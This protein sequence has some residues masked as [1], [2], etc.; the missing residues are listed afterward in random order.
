MKTN[1]IPID[2]LIPWLGIALI[3]GGLMV[4]ATYLHLERKA[5]AFE[6]S[7]ATLDRLCQEVQLSAELKRLHEGE[8]DQAAQDIDLLLCGDIL[9]TNAELASAD[10]ETR[11]LVQNTFRRIARVRPKTEGTNAASTQEH[12]FDQMAA[13]RVLTLALAAPNIAEKQ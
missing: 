8:V 12:V 7:T 13:E 2:R 10:R 5:H 3:A 1:H 6:A 4:A 11:A 9:L